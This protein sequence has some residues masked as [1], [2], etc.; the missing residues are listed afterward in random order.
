MPFNTVLDTIASNL[1]F[2]ALVSAA[3]KDGA[4]RAHKAKLSDEIVSKIGTAEMW[5]IF[6]LSPESGSSYLTVDS[7]DV[8][9]LTPHNRLS[10]DSVLV[11]KVQFELYIE[12][13]KRIAR[14]EYGQSSVTRKVVTFW[15]AIGQNADD[16]LSI[17][18]VSRE[19]D[20][21]SGTWVYGLASTSP[22]SFAGIDESDVQAYLTDE[23]RSFFNG[24]NNGKHN[25]DNRLSKGDLLKN[26]A[27]VQTMRDSYLIS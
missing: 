12:T 25:Q 14:N 6:N 24:L 23:L 22:E 8:I 17:R 26:P 27:L 5:T 9:S 2:K 3:K 10:P 16:T 21:A 20:K 1:S 15:L 18:Y 19:K 11:M 7:N 4:K 13:T